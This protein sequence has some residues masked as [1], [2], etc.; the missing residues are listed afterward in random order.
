MGCHLPTGTPDVGRRL[1]PKYLEILTEPEIWG[2]RA[3][4]S[5]MAKALVADDLFVPAKKGGESATGP[6]LTDC[7]RPGTKR[8]L[9]VD[10]HGTPLR[11]VLSGANRHEA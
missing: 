11:A 9:D 2:C 10:R 8:H 7:G 3:D 5:G 1:N 6:N 4:L